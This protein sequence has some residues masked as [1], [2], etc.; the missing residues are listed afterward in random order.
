MEWKFHP[1]QKD[2]IATGSDDCNLMIWQIPEEGLE[3]DMTDPMVTH[4]G[5]GKKVGILSWHPSAEHV[6]ATASMDHT[7]KLWYALCVMKPCHQPASQG[8]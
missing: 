7:V 6:L 1:Y 2:L 4:T 3:K 8:H 5:H